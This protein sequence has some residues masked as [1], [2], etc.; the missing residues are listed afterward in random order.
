[1]LLCDLDLDNC[2]SDEQTDNLQ[3]VTNAMFLYF[4]PYKSNRGLNYLPSDVSVD[5]TVAPKTKFFPNQVIQ[6]N[7]TLCTIHAEYEVAFH[8]PSFPVLGLWI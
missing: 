6:K 3:G 4:R 8:K 1:M 7:C 2:H 5:N